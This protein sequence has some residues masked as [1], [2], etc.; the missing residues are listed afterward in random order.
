MTSPADRDKRGFRATP[1]CVY[2]YI[3][4]N[5]IY[6]KVKYVTIVFVLVHL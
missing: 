2:I 3:F 1:I 4:F 6:P 5:T